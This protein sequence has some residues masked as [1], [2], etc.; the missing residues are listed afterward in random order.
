MKAIE[1]QLADYEGMRRL[2][3]QTEST[4]RRVVRGLF[5]LSDG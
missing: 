4:M 1:D 2:K 5:G 3:E